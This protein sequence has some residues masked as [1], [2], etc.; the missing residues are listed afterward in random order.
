LLIAASVGAAVFLSFAV[1]SYRE[2][3]RFGEAKRAELQANA[4]VLAA[5][6]AQA[7][8][9]GNRAAALQALNAI[10]RMPDV[11]FAEIRTENGIFAQAGMGV[12]LTSGGNA[13]PS[14]WSMLTQGS[15]YATAEIVNGG[16]RI[17]R[18]GLLAD[19]SELAKRFRQALVAAAVSAAA[20]IAIGLLIASRLQRSITRPLGE[21]AATMNR[22][23]LTSDF[24]QRA[25][26]RSNDETGQLVDSFNDMLD[27]IR[28]RDVAL[29]E[30]RAG[31]E[32][33]V[34]ERTHELAAA[35][36]VA[37]SANRAKSEFLAT[38]SHEIRTPMNGMLVM[39]ELLAGTELPARQQRYAE[40]IV[41]S[42]QTLLTIINDILDISK[43]EA[44]KLELEQGRVHVGTLV[45]DVLSLF[46]ERASSKKLDMAAAIG[47]DVPQAIEGDPVRLSQILA[48]LVNNALKFTESGHVKLFVRRRG[49]GAGNADLLFAVE[50][51]GIGIEP[52]KV[53]RIF[54]AF[55]QADQ[56]TTRRFGGTGLGLSICQRLVTAMGGRIWVESVPGKGSAFA[57]TLTARVL[58]DVAEPRVEQRGSAFVAVDGSATRSVIVQALAESGYA[59]SRMTPHESPAN[60]NVLFGSAEWIEE[61]LPPPHADGLTVICV[62]GV[63][64]SRVDRLL[65]AG[66]VQGVLT[67]PASST[68][69]RE[70]LRAI[71]AG[72]LASL[73]DTRRAGPA[74]DLPEVKSLSVLVADDSP[75]NREV[76]TEALARLKARTQAVE[77]GAQAVEAFK[78]GRFD[79]VLMDCS[80]PEMDGFAATRAI[81]AWETQNGLQRIP[82]VALT[83][84]VAGSAADSWRDAGMDDYLTKPFTIRSLAEC[85]ARWQPAESLA[86]RADRADAD[87]DSVSEA[88]DSRSD[89]ILD[90]AVLSSLRTMAGGN[91]AMLD[92]IF[93]LFRAHAPARMAALRDAFAAADLEQVAVEAHALKSPSLNIGALRVGALCAVIEADARAGDDALVSGPAL[94]QLEVELKA[95]M[96]ALDR[97]RPAEN[98]VAA[99]V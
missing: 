98:L 47:A 10:G 79:L 16:Q 56:S 77:D 23:R 38:M 49:G 30:H 99:A 6:V 52:D 19:T 63:G 28:N 45:E 72:T 51:T 62:A 21:L 95:V 44:G 31:L 70:I 42:G 50:D 54:E 13:D 14:L 33:T 53:G 7:V 29:E 94:A 27:Q 78:A 48:N 25:E 43:I 68:R 17:G 81:R 76:V 18:L 85:L 64:N 3:N 4:E 40:T 59:I 35:R 15:F 69:I 66:L 91:D 5:S 55:S 89:E 65:S 41:R 9:E 67:Q 82:I 12:A 97:G 24:A 92:K 83:A 8:A 60:A 34:T 46:W 39:A 88:S 37:E 71:D 32:Q 75:V 61:M 90:P 11:R 2:L 96:E 36:D 58:E 84:H 1:G 20:A 74:A 80:M 86:A 22:V 93:G 26:R 87:A 73:L 57:F